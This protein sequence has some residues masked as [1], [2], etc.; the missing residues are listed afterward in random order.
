MRSVIICALIKYY[1]DNQTKA[2][3]TEQMRKGYSILVG[4]TAGRS[5]LT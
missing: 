1:L 2:Q 5:P 4:K 3:E